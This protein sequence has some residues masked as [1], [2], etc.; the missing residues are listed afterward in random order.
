MFYPGGPFSSEEVDAR[1]LARGFV[2]DPRIFWP[3][4]MFSVIV[5]Y[6]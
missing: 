2:P 5:G 6:S 1:G 3:Y 4:L